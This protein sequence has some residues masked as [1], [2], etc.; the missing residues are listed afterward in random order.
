MNSHKGKRDTADHSQEEK[1]KCQ[2][3]Y[4]KYW[5]SSTRK[6]MQVV[7]NMQSKSFR[8]LM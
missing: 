1:L 6:E 4:E 8:D 5:A 7:E 3:I 2:Q